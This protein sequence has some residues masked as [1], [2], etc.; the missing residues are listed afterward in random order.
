MDGI[1]V[2]W[3]VVA[4]AALVILVALIAVATR[5]SSKRRAERDRRDAYEQEQQARTSAVRVEN[6]YPDESTPHAASWGKDRDGQPTGEHW[7]DGQH[8]D[9]PRRQAWPSEQREEHHPKHL[10]R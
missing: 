7:A 6:L 3:I 2:L 1:T 8:P 10:K 4:L 9:D 5:A